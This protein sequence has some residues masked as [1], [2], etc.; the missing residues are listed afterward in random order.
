MVRPTKYVGHRHASSL[1]CMRAVA[2]ATRNGW[3][4]NGGVNAL[5]CIALYAQRLNARPPS[6][7]PYTVRRIANNLQ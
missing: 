1:F 2:F 4:I 7:V 5:R 3:R 6:L